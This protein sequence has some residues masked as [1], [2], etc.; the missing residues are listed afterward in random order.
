MRFLHPSIAL[1]LALATAAA[2]AAP[3]KKAEQ[4]TANPV[5][6]AIYA[7]PSSLSGRAYLP[8]ANI[9]IEPGKA[10][11]DAIK[12]VGTAYFPN[13]FMVPTRDDRRYALLVDLAPKWTPTYGKVDLTVAYD[14]YDAAGTKLHS[15]KA[16]QVVAL[17]GGN[18]NAAAY[19]ASR[20]AVQRVMADVH[21]RFQ[22]DPAKYPET[23]VAAKIDA[24]LLVDR[25][26][27][28][29]TGTAFFINKQGQML[30]AAH[31]S[32]D[33]VL[34]E[35]R[36]GETV[37]PVTARASSDLLD[38]AVLDSGKPRPAALPF[39]VGQQIV[40][41]ESITS[42][43]YPLRG[44]L[45]DSP[46]LT[47]GNISASKGLKGSWG[48]FQFS[49]PTQPGNSGGPIVS[50]NGEVLGVTV[51]TLNAEWMVKQGL[52]PQNINFA[53]DARHVAAFLRRENVV[54]D[55]IKPQGTGSM[56]IA[57]DAA[58][59]NTFLLNCYE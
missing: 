17:K 39:R 56:Q 25:S 20:M 26:E 38:V 23:G 13:Q 14:V 4:V 59:S 44:L 8:T 40:L 33:C 18:F 9:W 53:L 19:N 51:T 54:F 10:L 34:M 42:V 15:G 57:N 29:R 27:P 46:N 49:A 45:G 43:G 24:A 37:F 7:P 36:Q 30:T 21:K 48:M 47:R 35:V 1:A 55:A 58:L 2:T 22:P 52:I 31:V 41:G 5:A 11:S 16:Q 50:D 28:H 3:P 32:R 6:I 12:D